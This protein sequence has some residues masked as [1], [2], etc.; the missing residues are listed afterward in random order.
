M[1][2]ILIFGP[3]AVGKMS[4]GRELCKKLDYKLFHNHMTIEPLLQI[5]DFNSASFQKLNSKFRR[6]IFEE[7][8]KSSLPGFIITFAWALDRIEDKKEADSYTKI[9]KDAGH[10]VYYLELTADQ[11]TRLARN[12]SAQRLEHKAS[13]RDLEFSR[14]NLISC[15]KNYRLNS[16]EGSPFYYSENYL[17][18]NNERLST[19]EVA[20]K[21]IQYFSF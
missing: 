19:V 14:S 21:V 17:K 9:F 12:E 3:S 2:L 5:F 10:D 13:K 11:K 20:N 15:D 4:V 7:V 1:N 8:A 18:I 6:G 16:T